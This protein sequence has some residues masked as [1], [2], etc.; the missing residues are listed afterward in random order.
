MRFPRVGSEDL[1][2]Q[3]GAALRTGLVVLFSA[4]LPRPRGARG[5]LWQANSLGN[6]SYFIFEVTACVG[7][8]EENFIDRVIQGKTTGN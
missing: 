8:Q 7:C 6:G 3:G 1:G 2:V 5:H 4:S